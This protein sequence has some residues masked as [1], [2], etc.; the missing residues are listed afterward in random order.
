MSLVGQVRTRLD[1][2]ALGIWITSF[3]EER[4]LRELEPYLEQCKTHYRWSSHRSL[5][6]TNPEDGKIEVLVDPKKGLSGVIEYMREVSTNKSKRG[7]L[8]LFDPH[9]HL[10]GESNAVSIR[11][12]REG[13][14]EK[15]G[16]ILVLSPTT[17]FS[18]ELSKLFVK[19][20]FELPTE[21]ELASVVSREK[22][23]SEV[24]VARLAEALAGLTIHEA[25]VQLKLMI[26]KHGKK[27][28]E[29][30]SDLWVEKA[31]LWKTQGIE[32]VGR[33]NKS[34]NDIGGLF[35][36]KKWIESRKAV[37]DKE[38]RSKGIPVPRGLLLCGPPG[39]GKTEVCKAIA[40]EIGWNFA[41]VNITGTL[42][43]LVG[44][45]E[46][47]A[48]NLFTTLD[49][50]RPI[51]CQFD[52]IAHQVSGY[53]TSGRTDP[54]VM[55]HLIGM[56]LSWMEDRE[57]GVFIVGTTNEPWNLPVHMLRSGR[58]DGAPFYFGFPGQDA[59][60][61]IV[62]IH[63]SR[64]GK[65]LAAIMSNPGMA[66]LL[67]FMEEKRFVGAD[68]EQAIR[69]AVQTSYPKKPDFKAIY[70][71][72]KTTRPSAMVMDKQIQLLEE[73][74]ASRTRKAQ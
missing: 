40:H 67:E 1:A 39:T 72:L 56:M 71:S 68:V 20:Q 25:G 2:G 6:R 28:D 12:V 22:G 70:D 3:E 74:A 29:I 19:V 59:L 42:D 46:A 32:E 47:Y 43:P 45:S 66:D 73:W 24:D 21:Q 26:A 16:P 37:F 5:Y 36:F 62:Q 38:A 48:R 30:V 15:L 57:D 64:Y 33:P 35:L 60:E 18:L 58:F 8:I 11:A 14:Q 9:P 23:M 49:A 63:L 55:S 31:K 27:I 7:P 65:D 34:L 13:L 53:E 4:V 61:E 69:E 10:V 54:G 52:E 51:V 50:L 44:Q 41:R 17:E